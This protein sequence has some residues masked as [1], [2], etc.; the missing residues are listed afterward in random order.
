MLIQ[1]ENGFRKQIKDIDIMN[2]FRSYGT[3]VYCKYLTNGLKSVATIRF[4]PSELFP[5]LFKN[6]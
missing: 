6:I 1:Q 2:M 5:K 3:S 4:V